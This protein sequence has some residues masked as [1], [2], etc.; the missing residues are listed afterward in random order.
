MKAGGHAKPPTGPERDR[1]ATLKALGCI[2]CS[3]NRAAGRPTLPLGSAEA[4]HLLSGG[5]RR[6]H[7]YTIGLCPWHHR[8]IPPYAVR[9]QALI[10]QFGP[11]VATGSRAFHAAYGSDDALLE[12]QDALLAEVRKLIDEAMV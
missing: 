2:C 4:H 7:R 6:G 11:S 12:Y 5:R 3:L 9:T 1:I 10:Q 8:A